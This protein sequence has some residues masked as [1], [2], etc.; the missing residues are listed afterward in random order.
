VSPGFSN[1]ALDLKGR[2]KALPRHRKAT[3]VK[4]KYFCEE[5]VFEFIWNNCDHD[6]LWD[7]NA[8][9]VAEEFGVSEDQA[10]F[11]LSHLSERNHVQRV[12]NST[13]IVTRWP[14]SDDG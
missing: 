9:I 14:E 10:Y 3:T 8:E 5:G 6:G 2:L 12:G 1:T 11:V 13:Y 7:G 4:K